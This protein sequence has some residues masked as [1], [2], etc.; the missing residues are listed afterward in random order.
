[1][2]AASSGGNFVTLWLSVALSVDFPQQLPQVAFGEPQT[3]FILVGVAKI[4]K[5]EIL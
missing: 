1:M 5:T 4:C 3:V 2:I